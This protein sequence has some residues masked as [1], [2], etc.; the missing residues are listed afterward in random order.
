[1]AVT[2][3][4]TDA[5]LLIAQL[6]NRHPVEVSAGQALRKDVLIF[7][8]HNLIRLRTDLRHE[9]WMTECQI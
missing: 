1:M 8:D 7:P 3:L 5:H 6:L 4:R 2:N 9:H